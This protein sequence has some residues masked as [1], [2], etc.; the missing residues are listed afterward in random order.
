MLLAE[1]FVDGLPEGA[2]ST[3]VVAVLDNT[4]DDVDGE[5][6][7]EGLG[8]E[9]GVGLVD[10]EDAEL[11]DG[12]G[13]TNIVHRG[14]S[15]EAVEN[16]ISLAICGIDLWTMLVQVEF[17]KGRDDELLGDRVRDWIPEISELARDIDFPV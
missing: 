10:L 17:D 8:E 9:R 7:I 16:G 6:L 15:K 11:F 12:E 1:E 13:W 2:L 14:C 5:V 3:L 4:S